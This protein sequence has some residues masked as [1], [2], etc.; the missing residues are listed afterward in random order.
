MAAQ[1]G[2]HEIIAL[3]IADATCLEADELIEIISARQPISHR[4]PSK[5]PLA[6]ASENGHD[7]VCRLIIAIRA[8]NAETQLDDED[9]KRL[10]L[11]TGKTGNCTPLRLARR[12]NHENVVRILLTRMLIDEQVPVFWSPGDCLEDV[13]ISLIDNENGKIRIAVYNITS[14]LVV[15]ALIKA[16]NRHVIVECITERRNIEDV[17]CQARRL[18]NAG[19]R[20]WT[21]YHGERIREYDPLMHNKYAIF[22]N[23]ID[24]HSFVATGSYNFTKQAR[25]NRENM[26]VLHDRTAI[27]KFI[28]D[29]EKLLSECREL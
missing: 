14:P 15:E 5:T 3:L 2:Q 16:H 20:I 6:L 29:Y 28:R 18:P 23:N 11:N 19:I 4:T 10:I 7:E 27:E 22:Y 25:K 13:L 17:N 9:I 21:N 8:L 24:G 12:Y 26:L 1:H